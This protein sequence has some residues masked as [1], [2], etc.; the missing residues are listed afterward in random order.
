[1]IAK[2]LRLVIPKGRLKSKV[3]ALLC[4]CFEVN[5]QSARNYVPLFPEDNIRAKF[6][7]ARAI[8]QLIAMKKYDVGFCGLDLMKEYYLRSGSQ[9]SS[10]IKCLDFNKVRVVVAVSSHRRPD[11]LLNP[12]KRPLI[13]ATEYPN[14]ASDW[15]LKRGLAHV[16]LQTWGSTEGYVP[17]DADIIIDC[18][19]TGETL[20]A[21]K[22]KEIETLFYS[23]TCI[24]SNCPNDPRVI[25]FLRR[26]END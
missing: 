12:P 26:I 16:I 11:F 4:D 20:A 21:N 15:A 14:I 22:L 2:K 8:P 17:E 1:M 7:K 24:F 18:C 5:L 19:E 23:S 9:N 3:F 13:I 25:N 10:Q 6:C